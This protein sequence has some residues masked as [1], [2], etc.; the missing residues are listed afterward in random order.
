MNIIPEFGSEILL[1]EEILHQLVDS[2]SNY[3]HRFLHSRWFRISYINSVCVCR[4]KCV[5]QQKRPE[6]KIDIDTL[7]EN[8]NSMYFIHARC[9]LVFTKKTLKHGKWRKA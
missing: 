7:P 4:L 2:L 3:L 5:W 9:T 6:K 8:T 1:M